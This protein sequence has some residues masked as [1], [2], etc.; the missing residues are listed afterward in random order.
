MNKIDFHSEAFYIN[1][2][3]TYTA[4]KAQG[5]WYQHSEH[6]WFA[7]DYRTA[8]YIFS[9]DNFVKSYKDN[10]SKIYGESAF[11]ESIFKMVNAW[12][13][14]K[15]NPEHKPYRTLINTAFK[16]LDFEKIKSYLQESITG[17]LKTLKSLNE[18]DLKKDYV[19]TITQMTMGKILGLP[20]S[21]VQSVYEHPAL[22]FNIFSENKLTPKQIEHENESIL[23]LLSIC[24]QVLMQ[25]VNTD[26]ESLAAKLWCLNKKSQVMTIDELAATMIMFLF[27][28]YDN[29]ANTI[30]ICFYHLLTNNLEN[31]FLE[32]VSQGKANLAIQELLRF[33]S[34]AQI[35][36]RNVLNTTKVDGITLEK[37]DTVFVLQA[38]ANRDPKKFHEPDKILFDRKSYK[39]FAFSGGIHFC[40]GFKLATLEISELITKLFE[41]FPT[42]A[43]SS[44]E[45]NILWSQES[46]KR[47]LKHLYVIQ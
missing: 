16:A 7:T 33:D 45:D 5:A 36:G 47:E 21:I 19:D 29:I 1:P 28:G 42:L 30:L 32:N 40:L 37:G 11:D 6:V 24:K 43:L 27:A 18:I 8:E 14:S 2:Y 10:V 9:S 15:D 46:F 4:L 38:S 13:L 35:T 26:P 22:K 25:N 31:Q 17:K 34:S 3:P 39:N 41:C 12:I 23:D 44:R 20:E